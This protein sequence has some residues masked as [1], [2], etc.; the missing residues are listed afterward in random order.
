MWKSRR[1]G[2]G[3][4]IEKLQALRRMVERMADDEKT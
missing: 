2:K 1:T 4:R 3:K